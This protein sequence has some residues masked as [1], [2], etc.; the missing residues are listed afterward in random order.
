M[1]SSVKKALI[2]VAVGVILAIIPPPAGLS[3]NAWYYFALFAAAILGLILEPIPTA[4]VGLIAVTLAMLLTLVT[5]GKPKDSLTWMLAGFSNSTVWLIFT[6]YMF[7]KGYEKSGLGRRI[8][9]WLVQKLGRRTLGLGYAISLADLIIAPGTPSNTARSGGTIYPII[10]NIPGLYDSKPN[11]PSSRKIG[12]YLMW[13]AL[14]M[15][16]VT[17]VRSMARVTAIRPTAAVGI[18]SRIRP[19]IAA[20]KSAK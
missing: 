8:A 5:P 6:A 12:S 20:A 4:A 13:T 15:T 18:G 10:E 9:L 19:R 3:P 11:D 7:A 16:C 2:V 14:A 1:S 17:S